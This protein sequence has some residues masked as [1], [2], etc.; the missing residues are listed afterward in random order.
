MLFRGPNRELSANNFSCDMHFERVP[1]EKC[2]NEFFTHK[3][4][5]LYCL[6][7]VRSGSLILNGCT[8]SLDGLQKETY[9]K[10]PCI[11]ALPHTNVELYRCNFK[12]DTQNNSDT[13][14]LVSI[15]SDTTITNCSFAYF[16]CGAIMVSALPQTKTYIVESQILSCSTA[17]IY[18]QGRSC[19]PTIRGNR[20]AFCNCDAI[21]TTLDVDANVS[22]INNSL[23]F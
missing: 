12:G 18:I 6:I 19:K 9:R 3:P 20:F 21:V 22:N 7:L 11:V 1:N 13:S 5:E 15:N 4:E 10:V 8:L 2:M 16:N 23:D 14:G 17:G